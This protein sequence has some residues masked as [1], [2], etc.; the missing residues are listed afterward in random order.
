M[1]MNH[2][3]VELALAHQAMRREE[4]AAA[5]LARTVRSS[6]GSRRLPAMTL[7]RRYRRR[8]VALT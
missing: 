2:V 5:R 8:A 1:T 3:N 4:A 6:G 7:V